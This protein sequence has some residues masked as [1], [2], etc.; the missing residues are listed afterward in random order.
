[1]SRSLCGASL[2]RGSIGGEE[3]K[4]ARLQRTYGVHFKPHILAAIKAQRLAEEVV[5]S[6]HAFEQTM[7]V[8][9]VHMTLHMIFQA[10][11][12]R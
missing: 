5:S 10:K 12:K 3:W 8:P 2:C 9:S 1:M 6:A 7:H 4:S 11:K